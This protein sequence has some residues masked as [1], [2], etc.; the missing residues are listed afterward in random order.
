MPEWRLN[1]WSPDFKA[2]RS[3]MSMNS[4]TKRSDR[5][6]TPRRVI[7]NSST[8]DRTRCIAAPNYLCLWGAGLPASGLA[9]LPPDRK[10]EISLS[11]ASSAAV[12]GFRASISVSSAGVS[13]GR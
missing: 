10:S 9:G 7:S 12:F 6:R 3:L 1:D 4:N 13:F 5:G 2:R 11:R 8:W